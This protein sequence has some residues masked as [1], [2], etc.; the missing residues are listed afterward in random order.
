MIDTFNLYTSK[1]L[2]S[3]IQFIQLLR[4]SCSFDFYLQNFP[5]LRPVDLVFADA[6]E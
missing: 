6:E 2:S 1:S 5:I 3:Q 4:Q